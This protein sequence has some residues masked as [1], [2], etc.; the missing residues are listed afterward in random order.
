MPPPAQM[1]K[2][3]VVIG[4]GATAAQFA[5]V[6]RLNPGD[7]LTVIGAN[8]ATL[9]RGLAYADHAA[10]A[11]WRFAYLLNSPSGAVD[12]DFVPWL[13]ANW[14]R[15]HTDMYGR[16]PDWLGFNADHL[17]QND[18]AATFAPRAY[19]GEYLADRAQSALAAHQ[20]KGVIVQTRTALATDLSR[21]DAGFRITLSHGEPIHADTVDV[22]TGGPANQRFGV[23]SNETAF[24]TL[25]G[26]EAAIAAAL[27]PGDTVT[28]LGANAAMLDTLQF[29]QSILPL[30][31]IR[32]DVVTASGHLPEP[33]IWRRPRRAP[34]KPGLIGP[35]PDADALLTALDRDIAAHRAEGATMAELRPGYR[36]WL[37]EVGLEALLPDPTEQQK[38]GARLEARFR[39]GTHN[40]I[41]MFHHLYERGQ[42]TLTRGAITR[43]YA[44]APRDIEIRLAQSGQTIEHAAKIVVNTTGPGPQ[45]GFD[46]LTTGLIRNGWL[47]LNATNT[48]IALGPKCTTNLPGLR[49]L[50]PAVTQI[51]THVM[52]FPLYDVAAL[53]HWVNTSV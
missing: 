52:A 4:D 13:T 5:A 47:R 17:A 10:D 1:A 30:D 48:G 41:A 21:T 53:H 46:L 18:L 42:I 37:G 24:T 36:A 45:L 50:S 3:H 51:G 33:L 20:S 11:P 29:L 6:A 14:E 40:S 8:V 43:V 28:C 22:A 25:Y 23:D 12:P 7:R 38:I 31:Q 26:N 2:H 44:K 39:R 27:R 16:L 34:V 32:M 19:F 49:Y 35:F 15:L 9:G